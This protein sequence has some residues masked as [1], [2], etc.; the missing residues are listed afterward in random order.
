VPLLLELNA[1]GLRLGVAVYLE[2]LVNIREEHLKAVRL[3]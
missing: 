3:F 2:R 1:T